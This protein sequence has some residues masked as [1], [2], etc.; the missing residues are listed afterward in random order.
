MTRFD[1]Y[2]WGVFVFAI[3]ASF[4]AGYL[5]RGN[6]T[7][8]LVNNAVLQQHTGMTMQV[9]GAQE[10]PNSVARQYM[11]NESN[12]DVLVIQLLFTG[13]NSCT[14][15]CYTDN[16]V[17]DYT[18]TSDGVIQQYGEYTPKFDSAPFVGAGVRGVQT[19]LPGDKLPYSIW[20]LVS[21]GQ[22]DYVLTY[23]G[24]S[25]PIELTASSGISR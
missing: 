14:A 20:F 9:V 11:T 22:A 10:I 19:V 3:L 25:Y 23:A 24:K 2:R 8:L 7:Q 13:G 16:L 18:L 12:K 6:Q 1:F 15:G 4:F 5:I 17:N 21:P